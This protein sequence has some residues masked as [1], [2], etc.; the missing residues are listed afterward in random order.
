MNSH[1]YSLETFEAHICDELSPE[2]EKQK[3]YLKIELFKSWGRIVEL[4][5][6]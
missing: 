4:D 3:E 6:D 2:H 5:D 1:D